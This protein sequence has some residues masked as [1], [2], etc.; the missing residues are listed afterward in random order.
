MNGNLGLALGID[1][2]LRLACQEVD[3]LEVLLA[4]VAERDF[5]FLILPGDACAG[6]GDGVDADAFVGWDGALHVQDDRSHA[7]HDGL[8]VLVLEVVLSLPLLAL[9]GLAGGGEFVG[10]FGELACYL[11]CLCL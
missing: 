10:A 9:R 7:V 2:F 6:E 1:L 3:G 11:E 4:I 8:D 5:D